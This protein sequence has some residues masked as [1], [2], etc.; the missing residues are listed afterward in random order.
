MHP[1]VVA[2][3]GLLSGGDVPW[4]FGQA[5]ETVLHWSEHVDLLWSQVQVVES[6]VIDDQR[7]WFWLS[8]HA[9]LV[10]VAAQVIQLGPVWLWRLAPLP[11]TELVHPLV[12][13]PAADTSAD[14]FPGDL[15]LSGPSL[16]IHQRQIALG[17]WPEDE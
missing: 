3:L 8:W 9:H 1:G 12:S 15:L 17:V 4:D 14:R 5:G 16:V 6:K 7:L 2:A 13:C 11:A 10:Q